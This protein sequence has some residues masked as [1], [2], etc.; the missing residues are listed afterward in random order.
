ML[1]DKLGL[2]PEQVLAQA[3]NFRVPQG[4]P[5]NLGRVAATVWLRVTL[6]VSGN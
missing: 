2:T 4:V 1:N 5:A 6:H 3:Q